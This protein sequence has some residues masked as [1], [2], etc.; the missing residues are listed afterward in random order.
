MNLDGYF[1]DLLSFMKEFENSFETKQNGNEVFNSDS[2]T[3]KYEEETF[4]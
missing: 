4:K 1:T 3:S 2:E